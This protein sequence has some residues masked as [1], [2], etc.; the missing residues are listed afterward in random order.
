MEL[1]AL[2]ALIASVVLFFVVLIMSGNVS[3]TE[4]N[5][6]TI[7]NHLVGIQTSLNTIVRLLEEKRKSTQL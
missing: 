2:G 6:R 7:A 1:I 3:A 5:T 4:K